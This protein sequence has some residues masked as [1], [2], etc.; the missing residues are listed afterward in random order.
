MTYHV[1]V[2]SFENNDKDIKR[3]PGEKEHGR[4]KEEHY[5]GSSPS[6]SIA[7]DSGGCFLYPNFLW[8]CTKDKVDLCVGVGNYT[9]RDDVLHGD[10]QECE[11]QDISLRRPSLSK[12]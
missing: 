1:C 6:A 2:C 10:A 12:I 3:G 4:K 8:W 5:I 9:G 11:H 7:Q